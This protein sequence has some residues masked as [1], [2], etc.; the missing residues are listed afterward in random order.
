MELNR[1]LEII[2]R[3]RS[4]AGHLN[5]VI[6][7]AES[8]QPCEDVL[9]QLNAVQAALR[10]V[11]TKIICCEA[12][13]VREDILNSRSFSE[14]STELHRL[15]SL[16]TIYVQHFNQPQEVNYDKDFIRPDASH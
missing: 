15:Q 3:L 12:E 14:T 13:S 11:G 9:H 7:M 6:H 4:A 16:Y 5:A 10:I 1:Q 8:G 2:Q